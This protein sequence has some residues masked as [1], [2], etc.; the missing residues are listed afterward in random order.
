MEVIFGKVSGKIMNFKVSLGGLR[1]IGNLTFLKLLLIP[2]LE[3]G[4]QDG[5]MDLA[6]SSMPMEI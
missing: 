3:T 5:I 6:R 2:T 4:N 1:F